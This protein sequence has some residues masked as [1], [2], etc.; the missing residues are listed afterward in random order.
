MKRLIILSLFILLVL[1]ISVRAEITTDKTIYMPGKTVNIR[2]DYSKPLTDVKFNII[3]PNGNV[4]ISGTPMN[5]I[6]SNIWGYNY[7][8]NTRALNGTY[9]I[10]INALQGGTVVNASMPVL[11]FKGSF[12]VLAWNVN[13]YLNKGHFTPGETINLTVLITDKYSDILTFK[14]FYSIRDPLGNEIEAKNLT[15][16]EVNNGFTD[17]YEIP[18]GYPLGA[19]NINI[20]LIDSDG[21]TLNTNLHFSVSKS[22]AITPDAINETVTNTIE[23][24]FEFENFM[25]SDINIRNIEVSDSL[26]DAILIV[27]R[28]YLITSN[29]KAVMKIRILAAN[30]TEGSYS[31]AI[32]IST[33]KETIP[34]YVY[35]KIIPSAGPGG[36]TGVSYPG[37]IDY[38]YIIWYFAAGIVAVIITLTALRYRK[39]AKKKKE[40]SKKKEEK[41]EKEDVYYKSQEEYR[42]EYY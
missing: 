13:T 7:T 34:V 30:M 3:N 33:D 36:D 4:E 6:S 10:I 1:S 8:L 24:T 17:V 23:K 29:S 42:T 14:V 22:L 12:D 35:L 21:R 28:P 9:A 5:N 27:Q 32:D 38:S 15:L 19:S 39:V 20:T 31:G 11:T 18:A 16:T 26:K 37:D 2:L 25:D 40:E 41:K